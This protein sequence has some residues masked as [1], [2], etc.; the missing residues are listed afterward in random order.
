[1]SSDG[2][3]YMNY[4]PPIEGPSVPFKNLDQSIPIFRGTPLAIG[5]TL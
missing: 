5:A 1:M 4:P 2:R 3:S